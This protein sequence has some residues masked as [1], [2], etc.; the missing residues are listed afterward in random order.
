[1]SAYNKTFIIGSV[2]FVIVLMASCGKGSPDGSSS[3]GG[4]GN[5]VGD[6][7]EGVSWVEFTVDNGSAIQALY[8][9]PGQAARSS[10]KN[11]GR[12]PAIIYNHGSYVEDHGY[13][14]SV[15]DGYDVKDF[16]NAI[17]DAGY[18]A[19]APVRPAD[20]SFGDGI[21]PGAINYLKSPDG[22]DSGKIYMIGHSKGGAQTILRPSSMDRI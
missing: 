18:V 19:L 8:K 22:V 6:A 11:G 13:D 1:M 2:F 4:S 16:A 7:G 17:A 12:L 3:G 20:S 10:V 15:S 9:E 14:Q 5:V 21:I